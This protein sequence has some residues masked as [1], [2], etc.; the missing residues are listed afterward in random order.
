[1]KMYTVVYFFR[2][3]CIGSKITGPENEMGSR[4]K[5]WYMGVWEDV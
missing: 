2:T 3:Q 1:M 5:P 4:D